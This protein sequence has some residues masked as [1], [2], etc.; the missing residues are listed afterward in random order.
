ME[1]VPRNAFSTGREDH[2]SSGTTHQRGPR[3]RGPLRVHCKVVRRSRC[4]R[5]VF[6]SS[7]ER[8]KSAQHS[9]PVLLVRDAQPVHTLLSSI[10]SIPSLFDNIQN[11]Q[12]L[13]LRILP[14]QG[15]HP[16]VHESTTFQ[17]FVVMGRILWLVRGRGRR[18]T[19]SP[20]LAAGGDQD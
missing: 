15:Q 12:H 19:W 16:R 8:C 10:Q 20:Q 2:M 13:F 3:Y 11:L 6:E 4:T 7:C 9:L 18:S 5:L 14:R 1:N 17:D